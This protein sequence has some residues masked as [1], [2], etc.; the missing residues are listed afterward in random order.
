MLRIIRIPASWEHDNTIDTDFQPSDGFRLL[1]EIDGC[2]VCTGRHTVAG[3]RA[4][5]WIY[6]FVCPNHAAA[7]IT[8]LEADVALGG[9]TSSGV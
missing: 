5:E 6:F 9:L 2:D 3:W 8:L 1:A 7:T 4:L